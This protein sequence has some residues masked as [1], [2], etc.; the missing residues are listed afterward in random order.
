MTGLTESQDLAGKKRSEYVHT[1]KEET[2]G[3]DLEEGATL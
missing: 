3:E 2:R 1:Y